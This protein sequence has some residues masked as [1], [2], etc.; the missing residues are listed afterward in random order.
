MYLVLLVVVF[1]NTKFSIDSMQLLR[2]R[3]ST[4][5]L[6][7]YTAVLNLIYYAYYVTS[8]TTRVVHW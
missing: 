3:K 4:T 1:K 6:Q 5:I 7:L 8:N 2:V